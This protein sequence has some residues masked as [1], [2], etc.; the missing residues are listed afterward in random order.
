[1]ES[2]KLMKR[3]SDKG[4]KREAEKRAA[5]EIIAD[6]RLPQCEVCFSQSFERSHN[7]PRKFP[8]WIGEVENITLLCREHHV[9]WETNRLWELNEAVILRVL[10]FM[11]NIENDQW[12]RDAWAYFTNKLYKMIDV[13]A[14]DGVV[15]DG[16]MLSILKLWK[17]PY[18]P[19]TK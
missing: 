2:D 3:Y 7:F 16:F 13:A 9:A 10:N 17:I 14:E 12:K 8:Q 11:K 1:M 19:G 18:E 4:A 6:T 5:Y 15:I